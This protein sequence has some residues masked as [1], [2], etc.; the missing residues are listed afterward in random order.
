MQTILDMT[1]VTIL[2]GQT[3]QIKETNPKRQE[4]KGNFRNVFIKE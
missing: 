1:D 4:M 3:H 2:E